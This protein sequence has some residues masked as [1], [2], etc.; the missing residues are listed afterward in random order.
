MQ[1]CV[2]PYLLVGAANIIARR[3][4]ANGVLAAIAKE[5]VTSLFAAPTQIHGPEACAFLQAATPVK[6]PPGVGR[7]ALALFRHVA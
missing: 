3:F 7:L 5:H 2:S 1:A 4:S 6:W